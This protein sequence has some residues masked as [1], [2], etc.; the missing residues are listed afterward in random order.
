MKT[1]F[2]STSSRFLLILR[3]IKHIC[4]SV[5]VLRALDTGEV[6]PAEIL[7]AWSLQS[8]LGDQKQIR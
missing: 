3:E 4:G 8:R 1:F 7:P 6:G 5:E 2:Q